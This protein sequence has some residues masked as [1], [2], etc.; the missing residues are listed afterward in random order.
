MEIVKNS[1]FKIENRSPSHKKLL[2]LDLDGTLIK[3]KSGRKFPM[4]ASDWKFIHDIKKLAGYT[5]YDIVV[6]TN[7][8]RARSKMSKTRRNMLGK[9]PQVLDAGGMHLA[10]MLVAHDSYR[11]PATSL[12]EDYIKPHEYEHA[13]YVGDAAGRIDD[14]SDSDYLFAVNYNIIHPNSVQFMTPEQLFCGKV[15]R[16]MINRDF[17]PIEY[18]THIRGGRKLAD[19][20]YNIKQYRGNKP[21]CIYICGPPKCGKSSLAARIKAEWGYS[22]I[23]RVRSSG[24]LNPCRSYVIDIN[25]LYREDFVY[26]HPTGGTRV[27]ILLETRDY[28]DEMKS[29][30]SKACMIAYEKLKRL[31]Y[32]DKK[33]NILEDYYRVRSFPRTNWKVVKFAYDIVNVKS[34]LHFKYMTQYV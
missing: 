26:K 24:K 2:M 25:P 31:P 14:F 7:Q 15:P 3:T 13:I 29:N 12:L 8:S 17:D 1:V 23:A 4:N 10:Y 27:F 6:V 33:I 30:I 28:N 34:E 11:K 32:S 16:L 20:K 21:E 18:F 9:I 5:D 19:I 22:K